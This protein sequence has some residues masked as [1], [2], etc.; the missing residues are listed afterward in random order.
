MKL[1]PHSLLVMAGL[2]AA[3]LL[4][5]CNIEGLAAF[6]PSADR[7]AFVTNNNRLYVSNRDGNDVRVVSADPILTGFDVSFNP[8]GSRLL[9]ASAQDGLCIS[10]Y[11]APAVNCPV[12]FPAD[13]ASAG[14]L[15][16]LP[17]GQVFAA[18]RVADT[19]TVQVF[20]EGGTVLAE[21]EAVDQ[22]FAPEGVFKVKRNTDGKEW[23]LEP[24]TGSGPVRWVTVGT[25]LVSL[26]S[27]DENGVTGPEPFPSLL[28]VSI[29][30]LLA[31]R[32]QR[33]ITSG[34][35]SADGTRLAFR[36]NSGGER[37]DLYVVDLNTGDWARLV[38][39]ADFKID[40]GFSPDGRM[41]AYE[42]N[43][44]GRSVWLAN[45][46]GSAARRLALG[47][48]LPEWHASP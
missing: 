48:Q 29:T 1:T 24:Y 16:F 4:T 7:I 43:I 37:Y 6:A 5:A 2:L 28:D 21:L 26:W 25:G 34:V 46:D 45:A 9:Y 14:M 42:N 35:L 10:E 12:A 8:G 39:A 27:A 47:A 11:L 15:S 23:H 13:A 44:D 33:D 38:S 41:L 3:L 17:G 18:F 31:E 30:A 22:I 36:V 32:D 20:D 40:F 19:W